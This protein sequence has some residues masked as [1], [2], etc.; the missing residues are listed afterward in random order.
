[1]Y[2]KTILEGDPFISSLVVQ[3]PKCQNVQ[4]VNRAATLR[5][6]FCELF[7]GEK[8][9]NQ[10]KEIIGPYDGKRWQCNTH[11]IIDIYM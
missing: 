4:L 3:I 9:Q 5:E 2:L 7:E 8:N 6:T 1:M 10:K 11:S